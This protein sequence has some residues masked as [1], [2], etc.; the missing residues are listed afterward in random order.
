MPISTSSAPAALAAL[1]KS[2]EAWNWARL[3]IQWI[4]KASDFIS[5][6]SSMW[7]MIS[8]RDLCS[9]SKSRMAFCICWR[10]GTYSFFQR[11]IKVSA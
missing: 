6:I 5:S 3:M 4:R 8:G 10:R 7:I 2:V 1:V 9:K 11:S